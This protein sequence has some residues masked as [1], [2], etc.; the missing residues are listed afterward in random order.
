M[1][2]QGKGTDNQ[3]S[4]PRVGEKT[5]EEEAEKSKPVHLLLQQVWLK[6]PR[7]CLLELGSE[8]K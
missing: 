1:F 5:G 4:S 2:H 6:V 7:E 3:E 8:I